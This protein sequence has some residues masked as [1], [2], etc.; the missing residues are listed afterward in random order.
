[1]KTNYRS[2]ICHFYRSIMFIFFFHSPLWHFQCIPLAYTMEYA[3]FWMRIVC[4]VFV[5][6][7]IISR[8]TIWQFNLNF[9][10]LL[11]IF[12]NM[13]LSMLLIYE[14]LDN[15]NKV[16]QWKESEIE[17]KPN[18]TKIA[19]KL[20]PEISFFVRSSFF[21]FNLFVN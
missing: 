4:F 7:F 18:Q 13:I 11:F 2:I 14:Y 1:M 12:Y 9:I 19:S 16:N 17:T 21:Q 3:P 6:V 8:A 5:V 20:F 15:N 10:S